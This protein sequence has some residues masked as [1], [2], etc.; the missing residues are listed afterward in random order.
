MQAIDFQY[1][2]FSVAS[3]SR[4]WSHHSVSV[5]L[6]IPFQSLKF[7]EI[8]NNTNLNAV[9]LNRVFSFFRNGFLFLTFVFPYCYSAVYWGRE[10]R[11]NPPRCKQKKSE[12]L[13]T[14]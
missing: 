9:I 2:L 1:D 3:T 4:N 8:T 7:F 11:P 10:P 14:M 12:R 6:A 13:G 5:Q